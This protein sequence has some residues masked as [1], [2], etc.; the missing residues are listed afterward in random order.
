VWATVLVLAWLNEKFSEFV[1]EFI[2]ISVK[3]EQYL[4]DNNALDLI[5][6]FD[7]NKLLLA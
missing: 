3:A 2:M 7:L 1:S 4:E 5:Q 6:H